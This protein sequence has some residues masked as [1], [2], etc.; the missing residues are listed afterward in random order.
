VLN[1]DE[2]LQ[3][4][5]E[6]EGHPDNV[7]PALL[8]G[9]TVCCMDEDSKVVYVKHSVPEDLEVIIMVPM[10]HVC[11]RQ[12]R[13]VLPRSVPLG[14][15]VF[16]LGRAALFVSA[17]TTQEFRL[18]R[19][20]MQDRLHQP[21]RTALIP[22]AEEA[23]RAGYDAGALGAAISGSGPSIIAFCKGNTDYISEQM[24]P[25]VSVHSG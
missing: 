20:A 16:N 8:G 5:V 7:V 21:Y 14:D 3:L 4:A 15:A 17:F 12:A 19:V 9:F 13:T 1:Q 6:I 2:L 24:L 11:T 10:C 23:I 25:F 22:G 18:L